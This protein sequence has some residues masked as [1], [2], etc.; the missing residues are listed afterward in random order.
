MEKCSGLRRSE[1]TSRTAFRRVPSQ[2]YTWLTLLLF[3]KVSGSDLCSETDYRDLNFFFVVLL[4]PSG[5]CR[6]SGLP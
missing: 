1:K 6:D 3:G 2:K 5:E 4:S